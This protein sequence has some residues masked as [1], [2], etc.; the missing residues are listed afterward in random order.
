MF[1]KVLNLKAWA[2]MR[3]LRGKGFI[4]NNESIILKAC[5]THWLPVLPY[6]ISLHHAINKATQSWGTHTIDDTMLFV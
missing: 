6:K 4:S 1:Q 5:P 2:L 3:C